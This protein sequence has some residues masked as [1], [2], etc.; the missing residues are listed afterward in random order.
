MGWSHAPDRG[1]V[2]ETTIP[3]EWSLIGP[4]RVLRPIIRFCVLLVPRAALLPVADC[5]SSVWKQRAGALAGL[6]CAQRVAFSGCS[7]GRAA[8]ALSTRLGQRFPV[9]LVPV[10]GARSAARLGLREARRSRVA[11]GSRR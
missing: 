10:R 7:G 11:G 4:C 3:R 1:K 5:E 6:A 8:S 9:T 2:P